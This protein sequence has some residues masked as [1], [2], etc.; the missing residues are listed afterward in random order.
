MS[1]WGIYNQKGTEKVDIY[2]NDIND[3][4]RKW[5]ES[6]IGTGKASKNGMVYD[7]IIK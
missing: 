1:T 2:N 3:I 5:G 4:I 6:N 7:K